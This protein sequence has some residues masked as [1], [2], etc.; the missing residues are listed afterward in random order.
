MGVTTFKM[1][2]GV[3]PS[4]IAFVFYSKITMPKRCF[5]VK[6]KVNNYVVLLARMK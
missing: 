5:I 6:Q 1:P 2:G 4:G 3:F